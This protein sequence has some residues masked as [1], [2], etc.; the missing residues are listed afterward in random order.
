MKFGFINK[1]T[2]FISFPESKSSKFNFAVYKENTFRSIA[3][4]SIEQKATFNKKQLNYSVIQTPEN[5]TELDILFVPKAF[6]NELK[7]ILKAT[8]N[9]RTV[10]ISEQTLG[11]QKGA[12][13]NLIE[14][15]G[16]LQFEINKSVAKK[17][18][19]EIHSKILKLSKK[20]Y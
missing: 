1:L 14:N 20:I 11:A 16:K 8:V 15:K 3:Q 6:K 9:T 12:I 5:Q 18:G 7:S 17:K 4:Y 2:R 10:V 13:I 19:V